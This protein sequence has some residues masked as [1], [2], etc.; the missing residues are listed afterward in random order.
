MDGSELWLFRWQVMGR[1]GWNCEGTSRLVSGDSFFRRTSSVRAAAGG[2]AG[3]DRGRGPG[4][5]GEVFG[6]G[7][8]FRAGFI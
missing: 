1:I 4:R 6:K 5:G 3:K 2:G 8:V 7:V